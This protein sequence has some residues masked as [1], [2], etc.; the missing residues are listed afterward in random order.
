MLI[1]TDMLKA[2][3]YKIQ[4]KAFKALEVLV[5]DIYIKRDKYFGNARTIRKLVIDIIHYQNIRIADELSPSSA[6]AVLTIKLPDIEAV[7]NVLNAELTP[8]K[9]I[10]FNK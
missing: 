5:L 6:K 9:G 10:G 1:A 2:E 3:G 4:D 8:R 7:G